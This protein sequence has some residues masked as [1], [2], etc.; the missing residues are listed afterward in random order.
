MSEMTE[1][2][3]EEQKALET[4]LN[5]LRAERDAAGKLLTDARAAVVEGTGKTA[6]LIATQTTHT[7]LS[8]AVDELQARIEAKHAE[9]ARAKADDERNAKLDR[10]REVTI[11]AHQDLAELDRITTEA[12][13]MLNTLAPLAAAA[14]IAVFDKKTRLEGILRELKDVPARLP[15]TN[16]ATDIEAIRQ[17]SNGALLVRM[18]G[19]PG[20]KPFGIFFHQVLQEAFYQARTAQLQNP[21]EAV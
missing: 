4:R 6:A 10:L 15:T 19:Q 20:A 8:G 3:L 9:I 2:L 7:A 12:Y 1:T 5:E 17:L 16:G 14:F 18:D 13:A 11:A 21:K